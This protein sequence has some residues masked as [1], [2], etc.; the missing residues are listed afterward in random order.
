MLKFWVRHRFLQLADSQAFCSFVGV[1]LVPDWTRPRGRP[2]ANWEVSQQLFVKKH[3]NGFRLRSPSVQKP[4][5]PNTQRLGLQERQ[6]WR[7]VASALGTD[8]VGVPCRLIAQ[9]YS[10][11]IPGGFVCQLQGHPLFLE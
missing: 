11:R 7:L 10:N 4:T 2:S 1:F 3:P 8:L 5:A 9:L 6:M